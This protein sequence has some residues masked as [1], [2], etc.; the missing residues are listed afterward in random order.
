MCLDIVTENTSFD[1]STFIPVL[2]ERMYSKDRYRYNTEGGNR[3][4]SK[5][6]FHTVPACFYLYRYRY[7]YQ[8]GAIAKMIRKIYRYLT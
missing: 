8:V 3:S 7:C 1:V 5:G 2:R 6:P 4:R